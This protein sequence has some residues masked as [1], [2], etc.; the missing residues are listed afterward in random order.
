L[1]TLVP[2]VLGLACTSEPVD[3]PVTCE[4]VDRTNCVEIAPGDVE[5]LQNT[6]NALEDDSAI[7]LG[8]GTYT[9]DNALTIR[10]AD[11]VTLI[12]QGIDETT[13]DFGSVTTQVN[14]VDVIADDILLEGFTV[15]DAPKDAI[16]V[17]DSDGVTFR[18]VKVTWSGGPATEN[19]AYGLYPVRVS[20]VLM[21]D[22]EAYNASDAGIYV[23]QCVNAIVRNNIAKGNVAGIEIE[24]TQYADVYGNLA[25]G[26]TGGLL[27]FDLPGNPVVGRDIRIHDNRIINNNEPNFA[28]G[29]TVAIIP[30]GTGTV[31]MASRRVE[32]DNNTF[33]N[34]Q[35]L[36]V[37]ILSGLI[38]EGDES[39]WHIPTAEIV[40][41]VDGLDLPSDADGVFSYR[42]RGVWV[43]DNTHSGSGW[44]IDD[45]SL[46]DRELGFLLGIVYGETRVDN[47]LYDSI[48]ESAFDP[49]SPAG[50]SNDNDICVG[51]APRMTFASLDL[52]NLQSTLD[53][54]NVYRP[55]APFAPFDCEGV[56]PVAPEF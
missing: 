52:E 1:R 43:H 29:G 22:C 55:D 11:Q 12:G 35:S 26:N 14:G 47:V 28:P 6:V 50:N 27:I 7:V 48:G 45:L 44:D 13:L 49:T 53:L 16:R 33:E 24:N 40:G 54:D 41:D 39:K 18:R 23:G 20:N 15:V 10:N 37:A 3:E 21:E 17:E 38:V 56:R 46:E 34:N 42:T 30:A 31:I 5:A 51:T 8:E 25:E 4:T 2:L 32:L 19:G 9:F 36:D